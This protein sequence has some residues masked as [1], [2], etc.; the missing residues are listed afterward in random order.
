MSNPVLHFEIGGKEVNRLIDFYNK[1]FGWNIFPLNNK[2]LYIADPA[3]DRGIEGHLFQI[4]DEM[5]FTNLVI[6]YVQVDDIHSCLEKSEKLGGK[7]LVQPVEIPGSASH[8]AI[9][10][11]PNGNRIGLL[12]RKISGV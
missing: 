11:D 10:S 3:S 7:I 8:Y 5:E 1:T 9:F 6:I 12:Q 2:D 4:T